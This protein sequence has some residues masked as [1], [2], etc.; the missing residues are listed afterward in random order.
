[1]RSTQKKSAD[2]KVATDPRQMIDRISV[3]D[4]CDELQIQVTPLAELM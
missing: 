4:F 2:E 3:A 1:M